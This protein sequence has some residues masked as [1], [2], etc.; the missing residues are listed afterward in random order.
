M[1]ETTDRE[2]WMP[3]KEA[4]PAPRQEAYFDEESV[5]ESLVE[6]DKMSVSS[7]GSAQAEDLFVEKDDMDRWTVT[8]QE[9]GSTTS[10][11]KENKK[12]KPKN[13]TQKINAC[14][15]NNFVG[16]T[17]SDES[18]SQESDCSNSRSGYSQD[19]SVTK[20]WRRNARYEPRKRKPQHAF[21]GLWNRKRRSSKQL[22]RS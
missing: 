14:Q 8:I 7:L 21:E 15:D 10:K 4:R 19:G 3:N 1:A 6:S 18:L 5:K 17:M 13:D 12:Q 16:M 9:V 20:P 22:L 2:D 11:D